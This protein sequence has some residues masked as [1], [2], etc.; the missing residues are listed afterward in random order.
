[1]NTEQLQVKSL[2]AHMKSHAMKA[3]AEAEAQSQQLKLQY[4]SPVGN[5][6]IEKPVPS[7]ASTLDTGTIQQHHPALNQTSLSHGGGVQTSL[8][9]NVNGRDQATAFGPVL[10]KTGPLSQDLFVQTSFAQ[11]Q[12][13][14]NNLMP[15]PLS[16]VSLGAHSALN[17]SA[18]TA[19]SM[20][21]HLPQ[22]QA[23]QFLTSLQNPGITH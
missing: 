22:A 3:R 14:S 7:S 19:A 10:S 9:V 4:N 6:N 16:Q 21:S 1:M 12:L 11:D 8:N 13:A 2:N 5:N 15:S 23:I 20:L 18:L 17:Q